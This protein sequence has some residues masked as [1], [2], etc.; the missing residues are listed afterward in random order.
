MTAMDVPYALKRQARPGSRGNGLMSPVSASLTVRRLRGEQT[1]HETI[2][3]LL[4][5]V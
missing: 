4:R 2:G 3:I 5:N 1:S